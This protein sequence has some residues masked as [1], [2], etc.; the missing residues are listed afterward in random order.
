MNES[1]KEH[2]KG[3][4]EFRFEK[5]TYTPQII[6][7]DGKLLALSKGGLKLKKNLFFVSSLIQHSKRRA[8]GMVN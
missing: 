8:D 3:N 2:S 1:L 4:H 5:E 6:K 7:N